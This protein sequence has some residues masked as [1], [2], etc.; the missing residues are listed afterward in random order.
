[1]DAKEKEAWEMIQKSLRGSDEID[2]MR[3]EINRFVRMV[4]GLCEPYYYN[5]TEFRRGVKFLTADKSC[6]WE[7]KIVKGKLQ[8]E[9]SYCADLVWK[10]PFWVILYSSNGAELPHD[11][12]AQ[13]YNT[14]PVFYIGM[15]KE[16]ALKDRLQPFLDAAEAAE[17][18]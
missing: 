12:V 3:R 9:F 7:I 6:C 10:K 14:F 15:A 13:A 4:I 5:W 17:K 11:K 18:K 2:R 8:V 16:F 1:M